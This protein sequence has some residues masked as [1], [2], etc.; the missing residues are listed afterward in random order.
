MGLKYIKWATKYGQ[1][2]QNFHGVKGKLIYTLDKASEL[3]GK[4]LE[5]SCDE[6]ESEIEVSGN[7]DGYF[8]DESDTRYIDSVSLNKLLDTSTSRYWGNTLHIDFDVGNESVTESFQKKQTTTATLRK[9]Y[10]PLQRR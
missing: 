10:M 6:S 1:V 4:W 5:E 3:T 9:V 8:S 7:T 2:L